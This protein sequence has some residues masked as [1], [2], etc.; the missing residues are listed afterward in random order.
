MRVVAVPCLKDNYA[1]LVIDG[2][3]RA[4]VV[5][6]GEAEPILAAI[7]RAGVEP[8]AIWATHH[9]MDH[10][11][12]VP[13]VVAAH[14]GI[15]VIGH[16]SDKDRI[17]G[18]T[19][20]VEHGDEVTLGGLSARIIHNPGHTLGA[21]SYVVDGCVFT[22]DTLFAAGCGRVFEGTAPMM[23]ASL[24]AIAALPADTR[25]YF[26]HEYTAANLKFAAAVEPAQPRRRRA[27]RRAEADLDAVDDPRGARDE[28]VPARG[29]RRRVRQ[30][31]RVEERLQVAGF[32]DGAG[33]SLSTGSTAVGT[34]S[35]AVT[36]TTGGISSPLP[37]AR[38]RVLS[39]M[40]PPHVR[41]A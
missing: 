2:A 10:V 11:G 25:V 9:H 33:P 26:G 35:T 36:S 3:D 5:D 23:Y 38:R 13:G 24:H 21:I 30:A 17:A 41:S 16:A 29:R 7:K 6:P 8:R 19:R 4:A 31:T 39:A 12:G 34:A 40:A 14:P 27:R 22:G 20:T 1:Y 15:E 32:G 37:V 28:P 18:I